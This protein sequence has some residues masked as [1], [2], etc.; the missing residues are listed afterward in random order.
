M[1]KSEAVKLRTP[2][3]ALKRKKVAIVG[4]TDHRVQAFKLDRNEWE[5]WGLNELHK[6]HDPALF[7]RWFEV[8]N[9]ADLDADTDHIAAMGKMDI[10]VYMQGHYPD[11]AASVP[12]PREAVIAHFERNYFT[13][14]IAWE[15]AF[16]IMLGAEEI[17]IYGVDMATDT[18]YA[19]QRNC[20]E[21]WLGIAQGRGIKTYVPQTSDLLKTVGEYGFGDVGDAF[22]LKLRERIGWLHGQDNDFLTQLRNLDGQYTDIKGK[23][24]GEY[25]KKM[26]QLEA[27]YR[28]KREP[29]FAQRNQ[30]YGAILDCE[31]WLRSWAVPTAS[32]R[33]FSPD[34]SKDPRTGIAAAADG[35]AKPPA[36]PA[37]AVPMDN[38]GVS[39][40]KQVPAAA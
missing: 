1:G 27:E 9:R 4:F 34:R 21:Y 11:I 8:H 3:D 20:C 13:S 22:S 31:F 28:D 15:T 24:E 18:E 19:A 12:F 2:A 14:S 35:I 39:A 26:E 23:L 38:L 17:H 10:P 16:A 40:T 33:E 36:L 5:I 6:Q 25:A 30:V 37:P 7:D 32:N 29:L